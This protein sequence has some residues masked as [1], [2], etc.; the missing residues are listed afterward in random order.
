M[1]SKVLI[2]SDVHLC[3]IPWYGPAGEER[4]E[5]MICDLNAA[6]DREPYDAVLF[7]G[8]Y[9]LDHWKYEP[10]GSY[11]HQGVSNTRRLVQ[12]YLSRLKCP[13]QYLIPGNHEQYGNET[14]KQL[15]GCERQFSVMVNG[16]LFLMLDTFGGDLDPDHDS[17]GT[18]TGADVAFIRR[19]MEKHPDAPVILCAHWFELRKETEAFKALVK[20]E[21]RILCL[22]CGHDH[23]NRI[24]AHPAL[25]GKLIIHDGHFSYT[26]F[27][28]PA[29]CPWGWIEMKLYEEGVACAYAYPES[30]MNGSRGSATIHAGQG[31][32]IQILRDLPNAVFPRMKE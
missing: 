32:M 30:V 24:E 11:L 19:V 27:N 15:T 29:R 31:P 14:W 21:K 17:D 23:V 28:D 1:P 13:A 20:E 5:K 22:L 9:S 6:Y 26:G 2:I 10:G 4:M 8:D 18:Y 25:G 16:Y 12:D 3:H 7:L